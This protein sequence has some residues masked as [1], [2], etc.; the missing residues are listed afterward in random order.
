M[1]WDGF[2]D[3]GGDKDLG[4]GEQGI[5]YLVGMRVSDVV[6]LAWRSWHET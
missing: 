5:V 2:G 3:G 1:D 6:M 4:H